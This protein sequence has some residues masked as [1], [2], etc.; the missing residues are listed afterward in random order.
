MELDDKTVE[1]T[2]I[3]LDE[4]AAEQANNIA[5]TEG[6]QLFTVSTFTDTFNIQGTTKPNATFLEQYVN[7]AIKL[8]FTYTPSSSRRR[9]A[10]KEVPCTVKSSS[11]LQCTGEIPGQITQIEKNEGYNLSFVPKNDNTYPSSAKSESN[12]AVYRKSSS[13]LSGGAIAGIVIACVV[14]LIAAA[15]AAIMLRKPSPP[16]DNTTVVDLKQEN[17]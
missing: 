5:K 10:E 9:L 14:V 2:D 12:S 13:G 4:D 16:V 8:I 6:Q 11:E 3:Y 17:I 1:F 15:V 7:Q